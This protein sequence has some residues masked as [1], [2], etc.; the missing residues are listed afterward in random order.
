MALSR[1]Q[2]RGGVVSPPRTARAGVS[3]TLRLPYEVDASA[4]EATLRD[5]ARWEAAE[6]S[7]GPSGK[8]QVNAAD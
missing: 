6:S 8:I 1:S 4:V 7:F 2:V 5:G 3:R